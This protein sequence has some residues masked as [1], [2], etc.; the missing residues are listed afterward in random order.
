LFARS[1]LAGVSG[2]LGK[3]A[4]VLGLAQGKDTKGEGVVT[5][6]SNPA[7]DC[8]AWGCCIWAGLVSKIFLQVPGTHVPV[9][10]QADDCLLV[11][12]KASVSRIGKL[13]NQN[14]EE[15][16]LQSLIAGWCRCLNRVYASFALLKLNKNP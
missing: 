14:K 9:Q 2:E 11:H 16:G 1:T 6:A 4:Q 5:L 7:G 3:L 8:L 12:P 15:K 10:N 13:R